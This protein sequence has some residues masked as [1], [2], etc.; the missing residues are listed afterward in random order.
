MRI[1]VI[2]ALS[3]L[4]APLG[5][6]GQNAATLVA[7]AQVPSQ[8]PPQSC[9]LDMHVH[10]GT[11]GGLVATDKK[12]PSAKPATNNSAARLQL[13]LND[14]SKAGR[15]IVKA[16]VKVRGLGDRAKLLPLGS[17]AEG[18]PDMA[19]TVT[20]PLAAGSDPDFSGDLVLPGFTAALS[21]EL[22]SVTLDSGEVWSFKDQACRV[23]P[24]LLML[25]N[26]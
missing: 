3:L 8:L 16:R 17:S 26:H 9:P 20:I 15:H 7:Q 1:A 12:D 5:A 10:Q 18:G 2:A 22:K 21:V 4:S 23:A 13:F 14:P 24:D 19:M 25:I 11:G 6:V